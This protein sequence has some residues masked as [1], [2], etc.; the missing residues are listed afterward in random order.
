LNRVVSYLIADLCVD[1]VD[2][3]VDEPDHLPGELLAQL[4]DEGGP[5]LLYELR[6]PVRL[7]HQS[8]HRLPGSTPSLIKR[9]VLR[10]FKLIYSVKVLFIDQFPLRLCYGIS[11][12]TFLLKFAKILTLFGPVPPFFQRNPR[13]IA[14]F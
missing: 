5:A 1:P 14:R 8:P 10:D 13:Q 2:V 4:R 6:G 11:K 9:L 7:A 3:L 12:I